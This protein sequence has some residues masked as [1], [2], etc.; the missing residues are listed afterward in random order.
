MTRVTA[1]LPTLRT[2]LAAGAAVVVMSH[3]GRPNGETPEEFSMAPVAEAIRLMLGHEVILL[4]DCI[5]DKVETAVQA[6]VPGDVALL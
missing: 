1:M 4:E 2:L 3:R 5:G 6:L